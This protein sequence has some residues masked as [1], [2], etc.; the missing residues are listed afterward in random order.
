MTSPG[1]PPHGSLT[2]TVCKLNEEDEPGETESHGTR[3]RISGPWR[4]QRISLFMLRPQKCRCCSAGTGNPNSAVLLAAPPARFELATFW[5][6]TRRRLLTP[7]W[8]LTAEATGIEPAG[9]CTPDWLATSSRT[10]TDPLPALGCVA[11]PAP[12]QVAHKGTKAIP[13]HKERPAL[14]QTELQRAAKRPGGI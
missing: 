13:G 5:L 6:T 14:S 2:T 11:P 4:A 1:R 10:V 3:T 9:A 12:W 8:G 7:L